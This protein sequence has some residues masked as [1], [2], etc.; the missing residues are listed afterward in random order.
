VLSRRTFAARRQS[1]LSK[2]G[3]GPLHVIESIEV[4]PVRQLRWFPVADEQLQFMLLASDMPLTGYNFFG[5]SWARR[6]PT[7]RCSVTPF[8]AATSN[9]RCPRRA[10]NHYDRSGKQF[11]HNFHEFAAAKVQ[12]LR[13]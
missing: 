2:W 5:S 6:N 9:A 10:H 4:E 11:R 13:P 12:L 3:S 7:I 1:T 8:V